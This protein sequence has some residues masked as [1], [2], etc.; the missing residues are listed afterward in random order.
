[1]LIGELDQELFHECVLV[2]Q[3]TD[4]SPKDDQTILGPRSRGVVGMQNDILWTKSV[5]AIRISK[6]MFELK[7][8]GE[9]GLETNQDFGLLTAEIQARSWTFIEHD[10]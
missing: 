4:W 7:G 3:S 6:D 1:M 2:V 10:V 8:L 9:R 5:M